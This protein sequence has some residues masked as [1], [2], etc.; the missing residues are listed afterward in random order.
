[1]EST[2]KTYEANLPRGILGLAAVALT[3]ATLGLGVVLPAALGPGEQAQA[4]AASAEYARERTFR[5]SAPD[6]R[7]IEPIEVVAIR[8]RN[9]SAAQESGAPRK[10]GTQG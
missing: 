2:M 5:A 7:Y 4:V 1:M 10:R 9:V 3:V 8:D 6:V